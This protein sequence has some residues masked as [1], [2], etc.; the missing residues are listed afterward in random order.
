LVLS[1]G[2]PTAG[3]G[4]FMPT[5]ILFVSGNTVHIST[6]SKVIGLVSMIVGLDQAGLF[7][8]TLSISVI[9]GFRD[10]LSKRVFCGEAGHRRGASSAI[11]VGLSAPAGHHLYVN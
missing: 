7:R 10:P 2:L 8:R 5:K 4:V 9:G 3:G 11:T 1:V 6:S